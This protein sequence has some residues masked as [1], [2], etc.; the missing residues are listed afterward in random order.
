MVINLSLSSSPP[1]G[2]SAIGTSP[3]R[4]TR[5]SDDTDELAD[6]TIPCSPFQTQA[7]QIVNRT[8]LASP[9]KPHSDLSS[10]PSSRSV[11]EVPASSP[12]QPDKTSTISSYFSRL[13]PPGSRFQPPPKSQPTPRSL[14]RPSEE[15]IIVDS[16]D[17]ENN[18]SSRENIARTSFKRHVTNFE[19]IPVDKLQKKIEQVSQA[20]G[21][22]MPVQFCKEALTACHNN[23]E[24]AINYL[25]E[26][27]HLKPKANPLLS[28]KKPAITV[29]NERPVSLERKISRYDEPSKPK[30]L[31]RHTPSLPTPSRSTTPSPSKPKRR[32]LIQ[33]RRPDRSPIASQHIQEIE[34]TLDELADERLDEPIVIPDDNEDEDFDNEDE[35]N[36]AVKESLHDKALQAINSSSIEDLSAMTN[37]KL[38]E[39]RVIETKRPFDTIDEVQAV[40]VLKKSGARGRKPR[41]A[42]GETLVDAIMEF[43]RSVNAIDEVVADCEKK[44]NKVK[45]EISLWDLDVK[46]QKRS[47]QSSQAKNDMPLT[48]TSFQGQKLSEPPI[49]CQPKMMEGHCTMRPFQVFGLNWMSLLYNSGYGC[50]LADEM[51]LGKTCQVISLICHLV[52]NYEETGRGDRPWPNLV[53]V[54][55]STFSN[56]MVEFQRFAPGLSVLAYQGPQAERRD[57][58]YE[59]LDNPGDYHVVLTTYTQVGSE[60]DLE[61]LRELQ[62]AAAIFDEG[63]KMK[64]P[65]TKIYKDLIR[66]KA[67]WRMLLTGT[68][69]QNNLM[70]MLSLLNF[71][72]PKQFSGRMD[73][74]QYMFSQKVTIRDVNNGAFL[75]GERVSRARTIL[76]PF[77][78]QRRKQQ[79]LSDMPSKTCNVA[80]CDLAPVQ[81]ELYE[82]YERLFKAGPAKKTNTG[83][84]SDQNNSWMQLRKAAIHPQLFRRYFDNKKVEQMAKILMRDVPQSELQQ[85]R[86]DHLIGELKNSSDFELHLWCRD[87]ACIRHLDVPEGS[88][89]DSGKVTKLLQLIH[90]Y[91]DNGDRVLVFSKFAKVI[92]ILREVLHTDGIKHCVLYGQT[93]VGERQDLIDDF[94]KDID[95]TAFLLTTGA[96]GTG[97]NLTSANK[98][99]IFD[100]SDNPQDD[101]QAEN[102]AHRLGQT[103]DVEVI[104]LLTAHTIEELIYKACQKKIELAEKVTGAVEDVEDKNAEENLEKEVRK[105]MADQ[106]TPS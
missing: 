3:I 27:R 105:M 76:E 106:M 34:P 13:V 63:H 24:D 50:I 15:P 23:V 103:R 6:E 45:Q 33:G 4:G 75:Y 61:A 88:W 100:Q 89:M 48:P 56:W 90:Q 64:N 73:Q 9:S 65:K 95:I 85:P 20:L 102:R 51:G 1:V 83:R 84:Q 77:I 46:G 7:T 78:L 80:Y 57:I 97:I 55:P 26:A 43:T 70:E 71:I 25:L 93:S 36:E 94:N 69:V 32:R 29:G 98:I 11:I 99:I 49:P 79:V 31:G 21:S 35:V 12:F 40:T 92:E 28:C 87:Y 52:E 2:S 67:R 41:V 91:R 39:L 10:S 5:R 72:D 44:A 62:P 42:I 60:D 104:R 53:V 47:S 82:E 8:S 19:Y 18:R 58:A 37:I 74:L 54:P 30:L 86:L 96:G 17:D 16:S 68:P 81:K 59:M 101:I 14:K 38:D 22:T 66:I